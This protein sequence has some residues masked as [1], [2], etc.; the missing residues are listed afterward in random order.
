MTVL[1]CEA[2]YV[3]A[4]SSVCHAVWLRNLLKELNFNQDES[5]Q[6]YVDKKSAIALAKNPVFHDR[7]KHINTWY[8]FIRE[9]IAKKEVQVKFVK[10]EDQVADIFTKPLKREAFEKLRSQLGMRGSSLRGLNVVIA[11]YIFMAMREPSDKHEPDP[12]FLAEA[13]ASVK[14]SKPN[15]NKDS[16][17]TQWFKGVSRQ[18][19]VRASPISATTLAVLLERSMT[20]KSLAWVDAAIPSAMAM[21]PLL[22]SAFML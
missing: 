13:K 2:E 10:S 18:N 12:K 3:A 4:T 15:E 20:G 11:L 17:P 9:S 6:I 5:T 16:S 1:T 22:G 14:Q 19:Q 8:H 21:N 7:S